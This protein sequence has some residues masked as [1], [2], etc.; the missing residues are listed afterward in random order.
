M[1][2]TALLG[3]GLC[4]ENQP[5]K[6]ALTETVTILLDEGMNDTSKSLLIFSHICL[7]DTEATNFKNLAASFKGYSFRVP[8]TQSYQ[9]LEGTIARD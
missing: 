9:S 4:H 1:K 2:G 3:A 8:L 7:E 5:R 6:A